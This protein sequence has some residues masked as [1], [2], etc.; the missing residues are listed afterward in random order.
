MLP[1]NMDKKIMCVSLVIGGVTSLFSRAALLTTSPS[2]LALSLGFSASA[3]GLNGLVQE[4]YGG[5]NLLNCFYPYP[6]CKERKHRFRDSFLRGVFWSLVGHAA[7]DC[8]GYGYDA[9][10]AM[11]ATD[12]N[13]LSSVPL[14]ENMASAGYLADPAGTSRIS[15]QTM[16]Y[17]DP[18]V[19]GKAYSWDLLI[20]ARE[21][22]R[23]FT[24][25]ATTLANHS[26]N[27]LCDHGTVFQDPDPLR[28]TE[29]G[30]FF[31]NGIASGYCPPD[32]AQLPVQAQ[33]GLSG[34]F[35][36][37]VVK[38]VGVINPVRY[39]NTYKV[40]YQNGTV[41]CSAVKNAIAGVSQCAP[42]PI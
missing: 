10:Q 18:D 22:A 19:F 8:V 39:M 5:D 16:C 25:C 12:P 2:L 6:H 27:V 36:T 7:V 34:W 21:N 24:S 11:S 35:N 23:S 28:G 30:V 13:A 40:L 26:V 3:G 38:M 37:N 15:D 31:N 32:A 4:Y 33:Q 9:F 17:G 42:A 14:K 20:R 41:I 1:G 29:N